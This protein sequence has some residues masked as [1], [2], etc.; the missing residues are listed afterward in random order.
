[1]SCMTQH[2]CHV[3]WFTPELCFCDRRP[4]SACD[5]W[6]RVTRHLVNSHMVNFTWKQYISV[7]QNWNTISSV[8]CNTDLTA[9]FWLNHVEEVR[10][11]NTNNSPSGRSV[12]L[13]EV[14]IFFL[15]VFLLRYV[16]VPSPEWLE[17]SRSPKPL[18]TLSH[19]VSRC[20]QDETVVCGR[21][22]QSG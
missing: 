13:T 19:T 22:G 14:T 16:A 7:N 4:V 21:S 20:V 5:G 11:Q 17:R 1:M 12:G 15:C 9:H 3:F 18:F 8:W 6:E 10:K 2:G